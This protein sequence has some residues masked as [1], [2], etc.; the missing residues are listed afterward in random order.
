MTVDIPVPFTTH[1]CD[2]PSQTVATSKSA[3]PLLSTPCDSC[4]QLERKLRLRGCE[5]RP[6]P[7][8]ALTG[9]SLLVPAQAKS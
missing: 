3:R 1:K 5:S 8:S 2:P 7:G 6:P 9:S 4:R